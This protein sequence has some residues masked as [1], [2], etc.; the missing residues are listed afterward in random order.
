MAL[1]GEEA[2]KKD[3]AMYMCHFV[4]LVAKSHSCGGVRGLSGKNVRFRHR[5]RRP[6]MS[7]EGAELAEASAGGPVSHVHDKFSLLAA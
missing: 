6:P 7:G 2:M 4:D 5:E 3:V 1:A